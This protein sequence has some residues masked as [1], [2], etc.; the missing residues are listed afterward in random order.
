MA[1]ADRVQERIATQLLL[2]L[3]NQGLPAAT[4]VDLTKL[5]YAAADVEAEFEVET[6]LAYDETV[7][8]H[9][10][11][12][13]QGVVVK[14]MEYSGITGRN[15]E[16][17]TSRY[18]KMLIRIAQ[19]TGSERRLLPTSNSVLEPSEENQDARPDYDRRRWQDFVPDSA[20]ADQSDGRLGLGL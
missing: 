14:L 2:E 20:G 17:L 5:G 16:Q 6:G 18:R 10:A 4:S 13:S 12:A 1:L 9:V 11:A 7:A 19:T 15:T 8:L 3:T